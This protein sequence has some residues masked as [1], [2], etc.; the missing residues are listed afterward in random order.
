MREVAAVATPMYR[1]KADTAYSSLKRFLDFII[2]LAAILALSPIMAL[3]A[4]VVAIDTKGSPIF[5]QER[6]GRH[7]VPFKI[8]KFRSMSV[9]A[10]ANVATHKLENAD[11]Y[12]SR[13]GH[14]IRK[15]SL[16]ELPQLINVLKG[17]MSFVGPRP[18]V[19]S[20]RDLIRLRRRNGADR[21]RPGITGLAQVSG[22]DT[23]TIREKARYDAQY[24]KSYSFKADLSILFKTAKQVVVSE[25]VVEGAN[26]S[27]SAN[28]HHKMRRSA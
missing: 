7:S 1:S 23:V 10:P 3:V 15:T 2:A 11:Q 16:D 28:P 24:A 21:V 17:D 8:Y 14:L 18:V 27:I 22:R 26:K 9:H 12:I 19:L 13:I 4:I 25:G 20:E 6:M 5:V